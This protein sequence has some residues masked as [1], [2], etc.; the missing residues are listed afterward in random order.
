MKPNPSCYSRAKQRGF[1]RGAG[2]LQKTMVGAVALSGSAI[3]LLS[4]PHKNVI[5]RFQ[6]HS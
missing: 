1:V 4:N 5:A 2:V 6:C 3:F